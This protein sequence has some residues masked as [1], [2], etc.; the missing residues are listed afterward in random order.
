MN[1]N[2]LAL[3][4]LVINAGIITQVLSFLKHVGTLL[5]CVACI[6]L[7]M[8]GLVDIV[9]YKPESVTALA[10][11]IEKLEIS[12]LLG[13]ILA[14]GTSIGWAYE[15]RGKKRAYKRLG[16]KRTKSEADDPYHPSSELDHDG[17]TP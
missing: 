15:R 14:G 2:E 12:R 8:H 17:E 1:K 6:Y 11:V 4:R 3:Q 16:E 5:A 13:Y 9:S 10:T 7:I